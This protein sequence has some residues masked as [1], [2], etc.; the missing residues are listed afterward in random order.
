MNIPRNPFLKGARKNG[1]KILRV[2]TEK[3]R[4]ESNRVGLLLLLFFYKS[5]HVQAELKPRSH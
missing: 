4:R 2:G 5:K 3:K 1:R